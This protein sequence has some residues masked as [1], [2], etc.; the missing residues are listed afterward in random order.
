MAYAFWNDE[1]DELAAEAAEGVDE[2]DEDA[3]EDA[4]GAA[5]GDT[6][7]G[8]VGSEPMGAEEAGAFAFNGDVNMTALLSLSG[9]ST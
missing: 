1:D 6:T 8:K 3:D 9:I 5:D 4:D 7:R 2:D